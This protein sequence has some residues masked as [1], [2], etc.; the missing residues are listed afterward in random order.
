MGV[1]PVICVSRV[2]E[3]IIAAEV[4]ACSGIVVVNYIWV[5]VVYTIIHN[6]C[7][8]IEASNA[9]SPC[10]LNVATAIISGCM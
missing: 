6:S 9:L 2:G 10:F 1:E 3:W 5:H 8:N 4:I 7:G